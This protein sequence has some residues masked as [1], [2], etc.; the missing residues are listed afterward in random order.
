VR[1]TVTIN[2]A[3]VK[4][5]NQDTVVMRET[6]DRSLGSFQVTEDVAIECIRLRH[7]DIAD[8]VFYSVSDKD[9]AR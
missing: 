7:T 5:E 3:R 2:T 9:R 1:T 4:K 6:L 8:V